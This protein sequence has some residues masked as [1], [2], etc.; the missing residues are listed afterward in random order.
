MVMVL[1]L[2]M[3]LTM[4]AVR[5]G[6]MAVVMW[7]GRLSSSPC[8]DQYQPQDITRLRTYIHSTPPHRHRTVRT[9]LRR[10]WIRQHNT[11]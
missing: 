10:S 6:A 9:V 7:D 4:L 1:V 2:V 5:V 3:V 11:A 8:Q